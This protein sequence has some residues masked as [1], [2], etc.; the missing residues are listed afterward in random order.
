MI[1]LLI[2]IFSAAT[3]TCIGVL[4]AKIII[5]LFV[6]LKSTNFSDLM[7]KKRPAEDIEKEAVFQKAI[8]GLLTAKPTAVREYI[9]NGPGGRAKTINYFESKLKAILNTEDPLLH[10]LLVAELNR[11]V[12]R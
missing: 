6:K 4:M 3:S 2:G 1:E 12:F 5:D 10:T 7:P 9:Q 8:E 11:Q